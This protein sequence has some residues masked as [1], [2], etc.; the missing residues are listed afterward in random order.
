MGLV[1]GVSSTPGRESEV[2]ESDKTLSVEVW[3]EQEN[4]LSPFLFIERV[5]E[6][7]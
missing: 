6:N 2:F 3:E 1:F 4:R 7:F 5:F